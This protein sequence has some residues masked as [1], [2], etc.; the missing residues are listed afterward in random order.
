MMRASATV[1]AATVATAAVLAGVVV[2]GGLAAEARAW[3]R[4]D[5]RGTQQT[6]LEIAASNARLVA[7]ALIG[8]ATVPRF[9]TARLAFDAAAVGVLVANAAL[10]GIAIGGYGERTLRALALHGPLELAAMSLAGGTYLNAR[11]GELRTGA[12]Y[13]V[14]IVCAGLLLAAGVIETS[15]QIGGLR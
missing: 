5:F 3:L 14:A 15:V 7:A 6:G 9:R 1:A 12:L 11:D 4:F 2:F 10:V 8:A 13:R